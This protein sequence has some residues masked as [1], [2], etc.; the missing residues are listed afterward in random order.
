MRDKFRKQQSRSPANAKEELCAVHKQK[1]SF[2]CDNEMNYY[3]SECIEDH[4]NHKFMYLNK[5]T[6]GQLL[7][8]RFGRRCI[9]LGARL[10]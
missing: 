2:Y 5:E 7:D 9:E 6:L 8:E 3:C 4:K 10:T 1:I